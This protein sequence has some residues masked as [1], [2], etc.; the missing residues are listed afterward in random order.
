MVGSVGTYLKKIFSLTLIFNCLMTLVGVAGIFV[1]FYRAFPYWRPY[2]PFLI[3]VNF[4]W[5][6][7]V[8][9]LVNI[10]PCA[11]IGRALHTGRFL[12]HHY[13]YGF[14]VLFSSSAFAVAFTSVSLLSLFLVN[15]TNVAI[16]FGRCMALVGLTLFLDDLPDVSKKVES[17][18]NWLKS[19]AY[20]VRKAIYAL[21]LFTGSVSFYIFAAITIFTI[22]NPESA[23]IN[24]FLIGTLLITSLISFACVGRKAWLEITITK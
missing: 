3:D 17:F 2:W 11:S 18:L 19:R 5:L 8:G 7:I 21:Q 6:V 10:F 13:V 9:A 1:G 22:Q 15:T 12:F 16:N 14:F 24:S 20:Q 23:F 4:F